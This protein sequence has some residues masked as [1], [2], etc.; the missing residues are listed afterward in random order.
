MSVQAPPQQ[1]QF[2]SRADCIT[3]GGS[4]LK[5]LSTGRFFDEPLKSIMAGE[6]FGE[7]PMPH[8]QEAA[9]TFVQCQDCDQKFHR[10]IL[11]DAW[12]NIY[13]NR[14]I[15]D[16]A[17]DAFYESR[18]ISRF[19]KDHAAGRHAVERAL[20]L[21]KLTRDARGRDPVRVLDFGCGEGVFLAACAT[22]GFEGVGVDFSEAREKNKR[23]AFYRDLDAVR[24]QYADGHFDAIV[25]FEVLEHLAAPRDLLHELSVLMKPG[26]IL[27]LETPNADGVTDIVTRRDHDLID[28]LGHINAFT[29]QTQETI[30]KNAGFRRIT[31][32]VVQCTADAPRVYKREL[33]R[34]LT[35]FLKRNTQQVFVKEG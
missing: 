8:L 28:P 31:P 3:C 10:D 18:G 25:L 19:E 5:T 17:I 4:N 35:P 7:D 34:M 16:D 14:W 30:A 12:I 20:L 27:I 15:T 22:F 26:G 2:R 9:W 6:N 33:R 23:V 21:E 13:Y 1:A 11:T 32:T 24:A 29:P